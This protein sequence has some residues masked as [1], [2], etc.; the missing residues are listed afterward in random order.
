MEFHRNIRQ[1]AVAASLAAM[2]FGAAAQG[3]NPADAELSCQQLQAELVALSAPAPAANPAAE[4]VGAQVLGA[5]A[6]Q[7]AARGGRSSGLG[8]MFS[9]LMGGSAPAPAAQ[10]SAGQVMQLMQVA[11]AVQGAQS[12]DQAQAQAQAAAVAQVATLQ[13]L[14]QQRGVAG[15]GRSQGEAAAV[16]GM[17]GSLFSASQAMQQ[18]PVQAPIALQ[19]LAGSRQEQLGG[20]FLA[21][22]CK[23]AG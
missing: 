14:A 21:K 13:A 2:A 5:L 10:G 4:A 22:G 9:G 17:L 6:Q 16:V 8:G 12:G 20:L 19:Q 18:A 1:T 11:Q 3:S 15:V 7:A 23:P